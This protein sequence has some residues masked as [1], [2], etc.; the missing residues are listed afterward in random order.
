MVYPQSIRRSPRKSDKLPRGLREGG[1]SN[2]VFRADTE[3]AGGRG[4]RRGERE[5]EG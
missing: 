3:D 4:E 5:R 1:A 2:Q